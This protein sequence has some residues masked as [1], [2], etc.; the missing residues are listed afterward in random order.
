MPSIVGRYTFSAFGAD[1]LRL[2]REGRPYVVSDSESDV[3]TE[4]VRDSYRTTR[5]R[6]VICVSLRK[7]ARFVAAM[8]VHQS[9]PRHLRADEIEVVQQVANRCWE[10]IERTRVTRAL[11]EREQR[12]RYLADSI[13]QMVWTAGP[14]GLIE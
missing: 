1:C 6:S 5:I 13:P 12:F 10:S 8:A 3:R 7:G 2:V 14:D 4:P 9:T 11:Q